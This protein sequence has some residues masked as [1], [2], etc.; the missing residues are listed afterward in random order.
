MRID[1]HN[2]SIGFLD[3]DHRAVLKRP[4]VRPVPLI[5]RDVNLDP[6]VIA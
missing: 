1:A 4:L 2:S 5:E 3:F 6:L